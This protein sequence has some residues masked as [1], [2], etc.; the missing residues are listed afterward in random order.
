MLTVF[1]FF[2]YN[3]TISV[4][5]MKGNK[6]FD[7]GL[8]LIESL[9]RTQDEFMEVRTVAEKHGLPKAYLEKIAQEFKHAGLLE[10]RRGKGG[11]YR[12]KDPDLIPAQTVFNFFSRPYEFC[13][14]AQMKTKESNPA[15]I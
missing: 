7:Y 8:V 3:R 9:K 15:T 5:F 6:K 12:L 10:S 13:P 4:Q 14:V 11:G 1:L 2:R